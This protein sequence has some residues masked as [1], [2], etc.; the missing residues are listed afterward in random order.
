MSNPGSEDTLMELLEL[1]RTD[2]DSGKAILE[3]MSQGNQE[4]SNDPWFIYGMARAYLY[5]VFQ[6]VLE[7]SEGKGGVFFDEDALDMLEEALG[8]MMKIEDIKPGFLKSI[9]TDEDGVGEGELDKIGLVLEKQRPGRFQEIFGKTKL[10]YFTSDRVGLLPPAEYVHGNLKKA[11][12]RIFFECKGIARSVLIGWQG[13][14][15]KGE[16]V[17]CRLYEDSLEERN[18]YIDTVYICEDGTV[19]HIKPESKKEPEENKGLFKRL[20]S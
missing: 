5:K 1:C 12:R 10:H 2:P 20:F 11:I 4:F 13:K 6:T 19:S 8:M 17:M 18:K 3:K 9:G 7:R 15:E 16:W 14:N